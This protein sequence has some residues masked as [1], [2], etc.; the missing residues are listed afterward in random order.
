MQLRCGLWPKC[1]FPIKPVYLHDAHTLLRTTHWECV[2]ALYIPAIVVQVRSHSRFILGQAPSGV[3]QEHT[4][5]FV[6][7]ITVICVDSGADGEATR[8]HGGYGDQEKEIN[9]RKQ[10]TQTQN[11]IPL[12]GVQIG[13]AE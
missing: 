4:V 12:L 11:S 1:H 10:A 3:R 8:Q 2:P 13:A 7:G 9:P 5:Q 6:Y